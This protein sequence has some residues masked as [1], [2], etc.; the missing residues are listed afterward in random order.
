[1]TVCRLRELPDLSVLC[2]EPHDHMAW[3]MGHGLRVEITKVIAGSMMDGVRSVADLSCG[4]GAVALHLADS[5]DGVTVTLGDFAAGHQIT[6]MI[7][8][9]IHQI[10]RVDL[11]LCCETIEHL[12]NPSLVLADIREHTS[13]LVVTT[14][15]DQ[16]HDTE[17][18]H[19][20]AWDRQG[21]ESILAAAGFS[22]IR[23]ASV[24]ASV[25][26]ETYHYGIWGCE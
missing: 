22:V 24:D 1:M 5:F 8:D 20:W 2:A 19:L 11:F 14:P 18:Q 26:G 4:N 15:L 25:F 9:T 12:E 10:D 7:E 13:K 6:G 23:H 17:E 21:V 16:W 3:G